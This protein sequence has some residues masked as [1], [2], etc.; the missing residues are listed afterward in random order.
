MRFGTKDVQLPPD[1]Y[2]AGPMI[3]MTEKGERRNIV[4]RRGNAEAFVDA[5]TGK[6]AHVVEDPDRP[7]QM[8]F[9]VEA[10]GR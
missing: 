9:L 3:G 8:N 1:A 10:L 4:V 5:A 2:I 6:V 7:G